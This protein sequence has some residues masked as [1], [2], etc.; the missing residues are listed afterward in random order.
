MQFNLPGCDE[1][2]R[3]VGRVVRVS[4]GDDSD[5][6]GMGIDFDELE[7]ADRSRI[8]QLIRTLRIGLPSATGAEDPV[9][10]TG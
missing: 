7:A 4:S 2:I 3:T 8:D 10:T 5:P 9:A 6:P 1:P